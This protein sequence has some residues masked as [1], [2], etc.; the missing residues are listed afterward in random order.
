MGSWRESDGDRRCRFCRRV[1]FEPQP[2]GLC[3]NCRP[4]LQSAV[5]YSHDEGFR[6][7]AE[8]MRE[9]ATKV[10]AEAAKEP[11]DEREGFRLVRLMRRI[12]VLPLE[13]TNG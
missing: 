12:R 2:D 10:V 7:G 9:S 8:W 4:I 3:F 11:T 1:I 6:A 5:A 13:K